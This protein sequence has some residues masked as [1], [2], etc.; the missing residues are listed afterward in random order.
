MNPHLDRLQPYP[1]E[2]LAKLV[3][4]ISPPQ[5]RALIRMSIGEPRH[6]APPELRRLLQ[7]AC[8]D[9]GT[10]PTARGEPEL[11]DAITA[12]LTRRF[13]LKT[14]SL[15]P[16]RQVLP[17]TGT[18]EGLFALAQ[19]VVVPG[20]NAIVAMPNP[21]YQIY[22]G[23]ALLAGAEPFFLAPAPPHGLIPDLESVPA[24]IWSRCQ[25]V[26]LC[27]PGNPT[28]MT[29][30][31]DF[32]QRIFAL[33]DHYGFVI[34]ADECYSELYNREDA[35][36]LGALEAAHRLGRDSFERLVVFH[37]LSKRSSVPGLRSGFAAGDARLMDGFYR[38]R[39]YHGCALPIPVQKASVWAWQDENHVRENRALYRKKFEAAAHLL[40]PHPPY[41]PPDGGFY[42]WARVGGDD[43][44]FARRLYA[45]Q[46]VLVLPGSYLSR[47]TPQGDPGRG[48]V[49][50]SLVPDLETTRQALSR[51]RDF[52]AE[53]P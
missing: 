27:S 28:G 11:R 49:R 23:A 35:P 50:I 20:S 24:S 17:L 36:P 4:G 40:G 38:Y 34:A 46:G 14:D 44:T 16:E 45:E 41:V 12:W 9:L 52:L 26:Y 33:S 18:R 22:E 32:Y 37:S 5:G 39:T 25:F 15:N 13:S 6:P 31:L 30:N 42:L 51:I 29:L 48:H 43:E 19:T 21:F 7:S 8:E 3:S 2:R 53:H 1:F 47:P 10:Y